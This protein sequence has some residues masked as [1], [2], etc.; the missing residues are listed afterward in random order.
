MKYTRQLTPNRTPLLVVIALY[1]IAGGVLGLGLVLKMVP[2]LKDP[3]ASTWGGIILAIALYLLSMVAGLL[4]F[5]KPQTG[6]TLSFINQ[7]LQVLSFSAASIAYNF[8]AGL[9]L[10]IGVDFVE[11]LMFKLRMSISS[12]QFSFHGMDGVPYITVNVLALLLIYL[13]ERLKDQLKPN[14]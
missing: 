8:V 2:L 13:L 11:T 7:I 5:R 4:L 1:Q 6:L 12:F 10:G 14:L 3:S 9:K